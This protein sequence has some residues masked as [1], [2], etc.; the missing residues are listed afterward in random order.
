MPAP[1][2]GTAQLRR[3]TQIDPIQVFL[4]YVFASHALAAASLSNEKY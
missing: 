2:L 4:S 1:Q 3:M